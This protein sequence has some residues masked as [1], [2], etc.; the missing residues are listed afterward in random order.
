MEAPFP[1]DLVP[2]LP[3]YS[4]LSPPDPVL[5]RHSLS[6]SPAVVVARREL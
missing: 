5:R 2:A 1:I 6:P 4:R 3:L